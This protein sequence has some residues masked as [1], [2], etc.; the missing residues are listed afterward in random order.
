MGLVVAVKE[1]EYIVVTYKEKTQTYKFK[2]SIPGSSGFNLGFRIGFAIIFVGIYTLMALIG[3]EAI[4][5]PFLDFRN[6]VWLGLSV[7]LFV[8]FVYLIYAAL[9]P[10]KIAVLTYDEIILMKDRIGLFKVRIPYIKIKEVKAIELGPTIESVESAETE[11]KKPS[12]SSNIYVPPHLLKKN[13]LGN[14]AESMEGLMEIG[15]EKGKIYKFQIERP[16]MFLRIIRKKM[17]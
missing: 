12:T 1:V 10:A 7:M 13:A 3:K 16:D 15:T 5:I 8:G 17:K 6:Y 11:E 4:D 14:K 9:Y 2:C